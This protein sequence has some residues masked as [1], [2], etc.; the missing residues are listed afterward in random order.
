MSWLRIV[1]I[2]TCV[3]LPYPCWAGVVTQRQGSATLEI[4][5]DGPK[6]VLELADT[7]TVTLTIEGSGDLQVKLPRQWPASSRWLLVEGAKI[8]RETIA[9]GRVRWRQTSRYAPREPG[10]AVAF[11]YPEVQIRDGGDDA[12]VV[13]EPI[14]FT[15]TTTITQPD[16]AALRDITGIEDLPPIETPAPREWLGWLTVGLIW[17]LAAVFVAMRYLRRRKPRS[18]LQRARYELERLLALKL[19]DAGRGERFITLLTMLVRSYLERDLH[20]PARRQTTREALQGLGEDVSLTNDSK[21]FV[22]DLL[23]RG[24]AIKYANV[25]ITPEECHA[26]AEKV[27][28]FLQHRQDAPANKSG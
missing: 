5:F 19:P 22:T 1:L 18:P 20:L 15:V 4:H 17:A 23:E 27:R 26:W 14:D 2:L 24:D 7:I 9:P 21:K 28:Q 11:V 13:W 12:S 8:S 16:R 10:K 3:W 25:E 6:P